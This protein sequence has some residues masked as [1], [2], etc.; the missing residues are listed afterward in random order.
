MCAGTV[1]PARNFRSTTTLPVVS[2]LCNTS[3]STPSYGPGCHD[4]SSA[5]AMY[6][7]MPSSNALEGELQGCFRP[8][9]PES[10]RALNSKRKGPFRRRLVLALIGFGVFGALTWVVLGRRPGA[11][12]R[13][14]AEMR[15]TGEKFTLAELGLDRPARTNAA[16]EVIETAASR[17]KALERAKVSVRFQ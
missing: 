12:D 5:N 8:R 15:A 17:F 6:W 1:K 7:N 4:F 13:W 3:N 9:P 10:K 14:M 16:M 2:F 11:L